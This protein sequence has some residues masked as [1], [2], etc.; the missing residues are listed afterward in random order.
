MEKTIVEKEKNLPLQRDSF[1]FFSFLHQI[2]NKIQIA[3]LM[4][5][6]FDFID[7]K[8]ALSKIPDIK[9]QLFEIKELIIKETKMDTRKQKERGNNKF[10][11]LATLSGMFSFSNKDVVIENNLDRDYL[12]IGIQKDFESVIENLYINALEAN[13]KKIIIKLIKKDNYIKIFFKDDGVGISLEDLPFI[14]LPGF[15]N[16]RKRK[17]I[18]IGL[19][20]VYQK[21]SKNLW[22]IRVKILS[23]GTA[24]IIK[25]PIYRGTTFP[26]QTQ[27]R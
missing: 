17:G 2:K 16:K 18:G 21:V 3:L 4:L 20:D 27:Q 9:Q 24:F 11:I 25:I 19:N 15:S 8:K 10:Y 14:F 5:D 1:S 12:V 6:T 7:E 23:Q 26:Y 22:D 13:A